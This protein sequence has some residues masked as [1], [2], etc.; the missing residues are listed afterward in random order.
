[1]E[2]NEAEEGTQEP[3]TVTELGEPHTRKLYQWIRYQDLTQH[4]WC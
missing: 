4:A 2:T 1:M 3:E